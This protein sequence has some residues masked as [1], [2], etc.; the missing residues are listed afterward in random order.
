MTTLTEAYP[1]SLLDHPGQ[2]AFFRSW[3]DVVVKETRFESIA[4]WERIIHVDACGICGT[5]VNAILRGEKN[6]TQ[7]GHEIAGRV[8]N[9]DGSLS[10]E[11]IVL[12]SSSAC[13]R[14]TSC[15]NA[16][17]D[18]CLDIKSFFRRPYFG[19]AEQM[20]A[21]EISRVP[22]DGLEPAVACLSEPLG[23]A[24]DLC[25]VAKLSANSIVMVIGLGPIG[26]MALRLAKLAGAA[27]NLWSHFFAFGKA[28]RPCLRIRGGRIIV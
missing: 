5:D 24:I 9:F 22:Y 11:R 23:V 7:V 18:L 1:P 10:S 27:K 13:G 26:L 19:M 4:P 3:D 2:A 6:Y 14:C 17:P 8:V 12:E 16:R 28:K 21:P 25:D 15:R 20:V